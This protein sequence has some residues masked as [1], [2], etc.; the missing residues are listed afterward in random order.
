MK[1]KP[2]LLVVSHVLPFPGSAGQQQRVRNKLIALKTLF[3]TTFLTYA[4]IRE[5]KRI[6]QEL[7]EYVDEAIVLPS[8][9]GRSHQVI[10]QGYSLLSGLK[11]SNYIL[12]H[13]EL[14]PNRLARASLGKSYHLV[15]YEYWHTHRS[16]AQFQA[17][18]IPCVLDMHDILWQ[19]YARQ[20][21]SMPQLPGWWRNC[22][23][24]QYKQKEEAAW[25][26]YD[27]LI[28]IN[29]EESRYAR[30]TVGDSVPIFYTPMG[31]DLEQWPYCWAPANPPRVAYYGG[32]GNKYNEQEALRCYERIM[33]QIWTEAPETEFWLVGSNPSESLK[34]LP[35]RDS[36]VTVTGYVERVQEILKTMSVVLCPF[37][38]KFG[39]RSRLVE[40]MA[41]GIPVVATPEAVYGMEMEHGSGLFLASSD[42]D[43]AGCTLPLLNQPGWAKQQ[44]L[45]AR[46]Q[47]EEKFSFEAT[48]GRLAQDLYHFAGQFR[49]R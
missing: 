6:E 49:R 42:D 37:S 35:H 45:F 8:L 3:D 18:G 7:L 38:A 12:G 14:S 28:A 26:K 39:F 41:L 48:Y 43:F 33:P 36:R 2:V 16:A 21:D 31:V 27:A 9:T 24:K 29:A 20:L 13:V 11:R 25:Q 44:S 22:A 1:I 17:R 46:R 34:A 5:A 10:S 30:Q 40:V 4:P 47:A 23:L 15:L 19:S 32:L